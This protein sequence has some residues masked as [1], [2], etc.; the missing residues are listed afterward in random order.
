MFVEPGIFQPDASQ[1][2]ASN[3][4]YINNN[5]QYEQLVFCIPKLHWLMSF[6]GN[7]LH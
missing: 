5:K 2:F 4:F 1:Q 7:I 6:D 3:E